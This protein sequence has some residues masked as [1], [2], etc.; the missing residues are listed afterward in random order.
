MDKSQLR[1]LI[2]ENELERAT[3]NLIKYTEKLGADEWH[4]KAVAIGSQY[5]DYED[6]ARL[7]I[8]SPDELKRSRNGVVAKLLSLLDDLPDAATANGVP[9]RRGMTERALKNWIFVLLFLGKVALFGWIWFHLQTGGLSRG[10]ALSTI[11][12][13]IP[14]F[15]AYIAAII[16]ENVQNR[17]NRNGPSLPVRSSLIW[18]T[19]LLIPIYIFVFWTVISARAKG[20]ITEPEEMTTWLTVIESGLGVYV[21][22][23]VFTLFKKKN[24]N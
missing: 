8:L 2:A 13:L 21:G 6:Q 16:N 14:I 10:E 22:T 11:G 18:I 1:L 9:K 17:Y 12:F 19:F 20:T 7:G 4:N 5:E 23:I 24:S 15:A 3:K